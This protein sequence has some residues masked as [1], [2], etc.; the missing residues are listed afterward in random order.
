MGNTSED[1]GSPADQ[2]PL[3]EDGDSHLSEIE[4]ILSRLTA[5]LTVPDKIAVWAAVIGLRRLPGSTAGLD[6]EISLMQPELIRRDG[7]WGWAEIRISEHSF[8][9][10]E[11]GHVYSSAVG[12][13]SW[14]RTVFQS[15][16][17]APYCDGDETRMENW[18]D[19]AKFLLDD[20][21]VSIEDR[22]DYGCVQHVFRESR[23]E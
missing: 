23:D 14:S 17:G 18:L 12:G 20:A 6:V 4:R 3:P 19:R 10:G 22:T 1:G 2:F 21:E 5:S 9:L 7:N 16:L 13:D 8:V 11:G 15:D